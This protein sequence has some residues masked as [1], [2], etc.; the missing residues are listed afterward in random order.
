MY[1]LSPFW[2]SS[3]SNPVMATQKNQRSHPL[4]FNCASRCRTKPADSKFVCTREK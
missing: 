3:Q 2:K 1:F 4:E